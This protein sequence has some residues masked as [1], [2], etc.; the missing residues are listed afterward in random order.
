MATTYV[1]YLGPHTLDLVPLQGKLV[2]I[3]EG[4]CKVSAPTSRASSPWRLARRGDA[5]ARCRGGHPRRTSTT[6]S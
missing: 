2:D 6:I 1:D 4:E 5:L 3:E